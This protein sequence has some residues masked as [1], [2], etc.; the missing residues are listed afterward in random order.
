MKKRKP[1]GIVSRGERPFPCDALILQ[2][3][4]AADGFLRNR[5]PRETT[6]R[7]RAIGAAAVR[8]MK[9]GQRTRG[10]RGH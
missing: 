3:M 4:V 6:S 8:D 9:A 10:A 1:A 2:W 5:D 7:L